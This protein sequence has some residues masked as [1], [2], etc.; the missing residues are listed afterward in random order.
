LQVG[1]QIKKG[2]WFIREDHTI[3]RM[4]G[5]EIAPYRLPKLLTPRIFVLEYVRQLVH[6]DEACFI[7][8][9]KKGQMVYPIAMGGYVLSNHKGAKEANFERKWTS[10]WITHG[11]MTPTL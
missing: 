2:D 7:Q 4:Y 3:I 8:S 11:N 1:S 6:V 9:H 5:D 10:L